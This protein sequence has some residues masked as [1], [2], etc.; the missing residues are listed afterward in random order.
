M[1]KRSLI[2]SLSLFGLTVA[3]VTGLLAV[4]NWLP[5]IMQKQTMKRF[6][7][8]DA[9]RKELRLKGPFLPTYIPE[10]LNLAWPPAEVY[11]QTVPFSAFIMH[12]HYKDRKETGL[13]IQQTDANAPYRIEP[14]MKIREKTGG[15]KITI[16]NRQADLVPALCEGDIPCSEISWNEDG[17][18]ITIICACSTQ[19]AIKIASS[20]LPGP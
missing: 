20:T 11:A 5:S 1:K 14:L 2:R 12:L 8:V 9:A 15:S 13:V 10:H 3:L 16:K 19:D 17:T 6:A 4:L 18:I 7:S